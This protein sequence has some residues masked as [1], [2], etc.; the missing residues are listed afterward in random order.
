MHHI[1]DE[2]FVKIFSEVEIRDVYVQ[3]NRE[4]SIHAWAQFTSREGLVVVHEKERMIRRFNLLHSSI[5]IATPLGL[6]SNDT[7]DGS[8]LDYLKDMSMPE[9]DS[10]VRC[11]FTT[12]SL[13]TERLNATA[14]LVPTKLWSTEVSNDSMLLKLHYGSA[15]LSGGVLR[16]MPSRFEKLDYAMNIWPFRVGF[17]YLAERESSSNMFVTPFTPAIWWCCIALLPI[18]MLAQRCTAKTDLEKEGAFI[19]VL[20]TCLQQD[21]SAVPQGISGRWTFLVLSISAMLIHAYYT[22]A[23]VSALMSTGRSGPDSLKSL[24][25]S[26]YSIASEDYDYMRY[27]MFDVPTNWYDLEYLKRKKL[28]PT[29]YQDIRTGVKMIQSGQTAYHT[30]YNQLFPYL[31]VFTDDQLCKL[32]YIDTVPESLTWITTTKRGQWTEIFKS[33]GAWLRETG[34]AKQLVS[35]LRSRPPPCR[36][37]LLAERVNFYDIAPIFG[38]TLLASLHERM[39]Q[40][41]STLYSS[42]LFPK[43]QQTT[44]T[45]PSTI[46]NPASECPPPPSFETPYC[47][48]YPA[49]PPAVYMAPAIGNPAHTYYGQET[50]L[51]EYVYPAQQPGWNYYDQYYQQYYNT[52]LTLPAPPV[53]SYQNWEYTPPE[54]PPPYRPPYQPYA[55]AYV[56]SPVPYPPPYLRPN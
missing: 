10:G 19:A 31:K 34:L 12:S 37:A 17:T 51:P 29:F 38:I 49:P 4:V 9:R 55:P 56:P 16:I 24:G 30:E 23:I 7:Y 3:P 25:D 26:R 1:R 21:A 2:R 40:M 14:V 53:M 33:S 6:Y 41:L 42:P 18:L 39:N 54:Y 47:S 52:P 27:L 28:S 48:P 43:S 22:S 13:I 20:A 5:R 46:S 36:A 32:Q 44:T 45:T 35:Q 50:S 15:D 11:A 8:F